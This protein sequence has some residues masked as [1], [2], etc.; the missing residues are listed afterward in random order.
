MTEA[1][2]P[3]S[4]RNEATIRGTARIVQAFVRRN[5]LFASDVSSLI[6]AVHSSLSELRQTGQLKYAPQRPAISIQKSLSPDHIVCLECGKA[7]VSIK[8]HLSACHDLTPV[9][10]RLKWALS[11]NY[12]MTA[13]DYAIVRSKIAKEIGLGTGRGQRLART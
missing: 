12:P 2:E 7:L 10:Y 4:L 6:Q 1:D 8:R 5:P 3:E 9:Q 11:A 13:P